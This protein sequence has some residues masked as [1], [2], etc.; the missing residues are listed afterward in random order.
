MKTVVLITGTEQTRIFLH[1][2]LKEYLGNLAYIKSYAIDEKITEEEIWGDIFL[3]SSEML[4]QELGWTI[5]ETSKVIVAQRTINF[6][7]IDKLLFL[8]DSCQVLLVNDVRETCYSCIDSLMN[9]GIDHIKYFPYY[10]G[11]ETYKRCDIAITPG[12]ADKIPN[13]I[14]TIINLGPRLIDMNTISKIMYELGIQ[15]EVISDFSVKYTKKIIELSKKLAMKTKEM[16]E[17]ER[18]LK[19]ELMRKRYYAKYSFEDIIGDS[20]AINKIK[21]IAEKLAVTDL[22]ILISG[23]TGTGKEL[24]AS[25]VHNASIRKA[26]PFVAVNFSALPENLVESELFGYERGSFT[27]ARKEGKVGLFEQANGGTIFLDEIGEAPLSVQLRLLRVLQEKEIM[28]VGGDRI[29][30]L[31]IRIIAATNKNLMELIEKGTFR[32]DLYYRLSMSVLKIP[33]LRDRK[34]DILPIVKAFLKKRMGKVLLSEELG[35][36]LFEN[37]WRGNVRELLNVMEFSVAMCK[38]EMLEIRYLPEEYRNSFD[39]PIN[40]AQQ[41]NEDRKLILEEIYIALSEEI[42][43]GRVLLCDKLKAKGMNLSEYAL[44]HILDELELMGFIIKGKGKTGIRLTQKAVQ[45]FE[46]G[47][48]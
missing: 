45:L 6:I 24:F 42:L 14:K 30:P 33:P 34:Q 46:A 13:E 26:A 10:P 32:E 9:L 20:N 28:K 3:F 2:Q 36:A 23:E 16:I 22:S 43:L 44:R 12:E 11:I 27:G 38:G 29:V 15:D 1:E 21:E 39:P 17:N 18:N 8:P 48:G 5:P 19:N 35:E 31:D 40:V 25:A 47:N 37:N 7:N 41:L 4:R